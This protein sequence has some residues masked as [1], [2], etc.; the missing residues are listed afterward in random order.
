MS[1]KENIKIRYQDEEKSKEDHKLGEEKKYIKTLSLQETDLI[2]I[3][4]NNTN[5]KGTVDNTVVIYKV[6]FKENIIHEDNGSLSKQKFRMIYEVTE[7]I[8]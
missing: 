7:K 6:K 8:F 5:P 3:I 2:V 1:A 4:N